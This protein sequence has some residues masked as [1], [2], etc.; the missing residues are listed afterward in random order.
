MPLYKTIVLNSSTKIFVW[1]ITE[2]YQE[3]FEA[4][5]LNDSNMNRLNCM[6]SEMHQR[7]FLSVRKLFQ[8]A[9]YTDF[10]LYYDEFGKPHLYD[11]KH[12]SITHSHQF[13]AVILSDEVVGIDIEL[14]R[15]K[16]IRIADKFADTEFLF[17]NPEERIEYIRKLTVIWGAKEAIFKI[18][19]EKGI[20]FRDHIKVEAFELCDEKIKTEL[21]FDDIIRDFCVCFEEFESNDTNGLKQSFT[22]VYAFE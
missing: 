4:V 19:N 3:L 2:S 12:I 10:D 20:S 18:R 14:Q 11:G 8:K 7:A 9:G 17:L 6:K 21:H 5:V 1:E 16:I 22:L 15:E 13:S